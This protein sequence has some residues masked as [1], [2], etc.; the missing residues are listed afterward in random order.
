MPSDRIFGLICL[1]TAVAY[2]AAATQIQT[3]LFSGEFLPKLFPLM[4]GGVAAICSLSIL[5]KPDPDPAWPGPATWGA[6]AIAVLVLALYA[7]FLTPLGF[8]LPTALAA[9]ILSYQISPRVR[10]AILSGLGLS[11][12]LFLLFKYALGLGNIVAYR[13]PTGEKLWDAFTILIPFVGH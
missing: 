8:L 7:V 3:N 1:I 11:L 12:G 13:I 10:P 5:F 2:I 9:G 6:M 4:I